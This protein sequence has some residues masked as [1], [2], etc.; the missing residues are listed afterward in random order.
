MV[1]DEVYD[2]A[3]QDAIAEFVVRW[4][5]QEVDPLKA[6]LA[7]LRGKVEVLTALLA[8]KQRKGSSNA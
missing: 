8:D 6:E 4:V 5:E 7:E 3:F 2:D 1:R